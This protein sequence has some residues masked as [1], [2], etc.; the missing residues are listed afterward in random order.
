MVDFSFIRHLLSQSNPPS[1]LHVAYFHNKEGGTVKHVLQNWELV[2]SN[3][4]CRNRSVN[5]NAEQ[6]W[7]TCFCEHA[8]GEHETLRRIH[9]TRIHKQRACFLENELKCV[10]A[11]LNVF[12]WLNIAQRITRKMFVHSSAE[13]WKRQLKWSAWHSRFPA[14]FA[15]FMTAYEVCTELWPSL[16]KLFLRVYKMWLEAQS[17]WSHWKRGRVCDRQM[18]V[19]SSHLTSSSSFSHLFVPCW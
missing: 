5:L 12:V 2:F 10:L 8:Y 11:V 3:E 6:V 9:H 19:L 17:W 14:A 1:T 15:V 13:E 16:N 7:L 18:L 4:G